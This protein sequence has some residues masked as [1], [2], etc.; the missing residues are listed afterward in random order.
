MSKEFYNGEEFVENAVC[1]H[2]GKIHDWDED[3]CVVYDGKFICFD[4]YDNYYGY[5][6]ECGKLYKYKD[7]NDDIICNDCLSKAGDNNK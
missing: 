7:M 6:N 5:C 4:C 3:E 1:G 2:C